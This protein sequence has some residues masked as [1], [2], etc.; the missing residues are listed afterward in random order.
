MRPAAPACS[1]S[2]A[3]PDNRQFGAWLSG[4]EPAPG[5]AWPIGLV[6]L[7][8]QWTVW[9]SQRMRSWLSRRSGTQ[10]SQR[11]ARRSV[12]RPADGPRCEAWKPGAWRWSAAE[13]RSWP[14]RCW[15]SSIAPATYWAGLGCPPKGPT[16]RPL[17]RPSAAAR[18]PQPRSSDLRS[19]AACSRSCR[20]ADTASWPSSEKRRP[21]RSMR[22]ERSTP[23]WFVRAR[24][25]PATKAGPATKLPR[26]AKLGGDR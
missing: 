16:S 25:S 15:P 14:K 7:S 13:K 11:L 10:Q 2:C 3:R 1:A 12:S 17:A 21:S 9:S 22:F 4:V 20:P 23:K 24:A 18:G 19:R 8:H 26:T 5:A 6:S